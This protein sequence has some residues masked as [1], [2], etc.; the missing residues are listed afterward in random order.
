MH[1]QSGI[2]PPSSRFARFL[3]LRRHPD[4]SLPDIMAALRELAV[5]RARLQGQHP[6]AGLISVVA[7]GA[8][9]WQEM[10]GPLPAGWHELAPLQG[11]FSMPADAADIC[12]HI[13]SDSFDLCYELAQLFMTR[14][15]AHGGVEVL[16][17]CAGFR[18]LDSRDL[19]GFI[20]GTENPQTQ[21]ERAE[22]ALLDDGE[23]AGSSFVF[24]QRYVHQLDKWHRLTVD[25]QEH[26][27]G[28]SKLESIEL[29]EDVMPPNSHVAR[30]VI[31]EDGEELAILR[32]SLPY[33]Q[34]GGEHGLFFM[35]YTKDLSI[36]DRMLANMFGTSGDE[37]SDRLLNFTTPVGGAY[38]FAPSEELLNTVVGED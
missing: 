30:N 15:A 3:V 25:A 11:K 4:L 29:D 8:A 2:L 31:E 23:F 17:E 33:G 1:A 28:R 37:Q 18:Y 27:I 6:D 12:L 16:E 34:A 26:V 24:A 9:L 19:T 32:H 13:R 36:L 14:L 20:D 5:A 38:F 35:A 7:F 10:K 22:T 21:Q